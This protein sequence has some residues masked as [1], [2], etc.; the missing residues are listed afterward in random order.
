[1]LGGSRRCRTPRR[2]RCSTHQPRRRRRHSIG[3]GTAR[4][5]TWCTTARWSGAGV[6][7]GEAAMSIREW[8]FLLMEILSWGRDGESIEGSRPI[9]Y[10][11]QLLRRPMNRGIRMYMPGR[12]P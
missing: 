5:Q 6:R 7:C 1:V 8:G 12:T 4:R 10:W 2:R 11:T 3:V 9:V